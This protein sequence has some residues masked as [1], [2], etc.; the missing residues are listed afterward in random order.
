MPFVLVEVKTLEN[1]LSCQILKV[2]NNNVVLVKDETK[3]NE[4]ILVGRGIGFGRK[5]F[6]Y[7]EYPYEHIEKTFQT[8]DTKMKSEY[9]KLFE[10][11]DKKYT[12]PII[13]LTSK[14]ST[15]PSRYAGSCQQCLPRE[16]FS[17]RNEAPL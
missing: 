15:P 5:K 10:Q 4:V 1:M 3:F 17:C 16:S 2:L 7:A 8:S 14:L 6:D 12:T 9:M 11:I 13:S